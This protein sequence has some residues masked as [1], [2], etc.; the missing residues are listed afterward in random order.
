[1]NVAEEAMEVYMEKFA[2][3]ILK[4]RIL[5]FSMLALSAIICMYLMTL[6]VVNMDM[7]EYLPEDS[8]VRVGLQVMEAEFGE[9]NMAVLHV[10]FEGLSDGEQ[11]EIYEQLAQISN[12][13][14]IAFDA[15]SDAY[16]LD[17]F[18]LYTLT[19]EQ[20]LTNTEEYAVVNTILAEFNQFTVEMSGGVEGVDIE[21]NM[22]LI[23][24]PTI[25]ILTIILFLMCHSWIEPVIFFINIGI[26]ILINMGTN[27][28]FDSISDITQMIAGLLQ[29][30][31]S[32]DY[33]IIFLNR[34]RQE[35]AAM[36]VED[37]KLA[38]KNAILNSFSTI[39]GISF[40]TIVGML[41]LVF[42]SF[43]IGAD[44]GFVI[45]KG[46]FISLVC[47]FGVMPALILWFDKLIDKTEKP[48]LN[49]KMGIVGR[50]GYK[51]RS[52]VAVAFVILVVGAF[53]LQNN[54]EITYSEV[55]YDPVHQVFDLENTFVVLYENADE[56]N[57]SE[58]ISDWKSR[59]IMEISGRVGE[60]TSPLDFTRID[61]ID[62]YSTLLGQ[63]LNEAEVASALE[64]DVML[65]GLVFRNYFLEELP[66]MTM[67]EFLQFLQTEVA[68]NPLFSGAM[69][70]QDLEQL[71]YIPLMMEEQV[72]VGEFTA[73]ELAGMLLID[74]EMVQ[75]ILELY[76]FTHGERPSE[77]IALGVFLEFLQTE[78]AQNPLFEGAMSPEGMAQLE[79]LPAVIVS[80]MMSE[81]LPAEELANMLQMDIGMVNQLLYLYDFIH[82]DILTQEMTLVYFIDYLVSDFAQIPMFAAAFSA[83]VLT[84]LTEASLEMEMVTGMFVS[85]NFSRLMIHTT[86]DFE[87][88]ETFMFIDQI[89]WELNV[90]LEGQFYM[91]GT[92][93]MPHE[94]SQTFPS[95]SNLIT[96][97]TTI[98]FFVVVAIA[99]KSFAVSAIL[100]IVIQAAVF[101]TMGVTYFQDGGIMFLPLII[102][103]VLLKSRVIDYGILYTA[104]YIEARRKHGVKEAI[105]T[106]LDNSIDTIL[107]S[108]L[109][110]VV[111]TFV[112]GL[113]FR[114]VNIAIS[115]ILLLIAQGCFI[116]VMLSIFVLPSLV[117][118]FDRFVIKAKAKTH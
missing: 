115:E 45:A 79:F 11:V 111:I 98:A 69:S 26:A 87:S 89:A 49:L 46:V 57:M 105:I 99:F 96:L 84:E 27:I 12:I 70:M 77:L 7:T 54:I 17:E 117:A 116:G 104:N 20:G 110:I 113:L 72:M 35:K 24:I 93:V 58:I 108:G 33:S 81:E 106:A 90:M 80:E 94:M 83:E 78:V 66:G 2:D 31:L 65:V 109:I 38:M 102:A 36:E 32:M 74:V 42:M 88:A 37:H 30:A 6:V 60:P 71:A 107:T 114:G 15:D 25:I 9:Q 51:A 23:T 103:Q 63:R 22:H 112:V 48:T 41:M 14:A 59:T 82:G 50:F 44:I 75:Q 19:F 28:I 118:V 86:F 62:A 4:K 53:I 29:V 18:T 61:R 40:T 13:A 64:M 43:T 97:L 55:D 56:E 100:A 91:L 5:L 95:E 47:V 101:I 85:D 68:Y 3:F 39:S 92:S 10:M 34:Y 76:D 73:L 8:D 67:D 21:L 16:V 1:M 52:V